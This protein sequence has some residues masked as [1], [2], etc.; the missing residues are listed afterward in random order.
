MLWNFRCQDKI[1]L[2]FDEIY[3]IESKSIVHKSVVLKALNLNDIKRL[4]VNFEIQNVFLFLGLYWFLIQH[5]DVNSAAKYP[6]LVLFNGKISGSVHERLDRQTSLARNVLDL[7][8]AMFCR[9]V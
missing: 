9:T 5:N 6:I 7:Q 8:R 1:K 2:I 3:I 4:K